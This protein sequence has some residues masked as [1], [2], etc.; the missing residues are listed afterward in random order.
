MIVA[1]PVDA[2][3]AAARLL[4]DHSYGEI[5]LGGDPEVYKKFVEDVNLVAETLAKMVVKE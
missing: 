3:E 2:L 4:D 5:R 1:I